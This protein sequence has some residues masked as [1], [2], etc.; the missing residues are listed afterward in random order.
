MTAQDEKLSPFDLFVPYLLS[1][2]SVARV[3]TLHAGAL[4]YSLYQHWLD[5]SHLVSRASSSPLRR[6]SPGN[7]VGIC[8]LG[9]LI[10][11][12]YAL[13]TPYCLPRVNLA[14]VRQHS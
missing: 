7:E 8:L 4:T 6:K 14:D 12:Q 5:L 3:V 1:R 10:Q 9:H 13:R 2:D 11:P